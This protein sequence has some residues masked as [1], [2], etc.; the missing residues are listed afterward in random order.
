MTNDPTDLA[1]RLWWLHKMPKS[2]F[3]AAKLNG[4]GR[5]DVYWRD[6]DES[7]TYTLPLDFQTATVRNHILK[8]PNDGQ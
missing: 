6:R 7:G 5:V 3:I 1:A 4:D 8:G 2:D